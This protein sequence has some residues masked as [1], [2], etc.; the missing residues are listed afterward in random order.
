M[1]KP[2]TILALLLFTMI[3]HSQSL[4]WNQPVIICP[5]LSTNDNIPNFNESNCQTTSILNI[6]PQNQHI[7]IKTQFNVSPK[8]L[9]QS[10]PLGLYIVG[11]ASTV[12]YVNEQ[13]IGSNGTPAST[14]KEEIAGKIDTVFYLDKKIINNKDDNE[15]IIRMSAQKNLIHLSHPINGIFIDTYNNP[16][17][18]LLNHYWF[19]ILPFG[20]FVLAAIYLGVLSFRQKH[21]KTILFLSLMSLFA[22]CQLLI[23]IIRG[24]QSYLYPFHDIR[25]ILIVFFSY[26]F[27]ISLYSHIVYKFVKKKQLSL[28]LAVMLLNFIIIL[29]VEAYD[30]KAA[31][32]VN[33]PAFLALLICLYS[34]YQKQSYALLF[35]LAL[36][37]FIALFVISPS[38]FLDRYFYYVVAC[39]LVFLFIQQALDLSNQTK[40]H[41][42]EKARADQLQL[43]IDQNNEKTNPAQLKIKG[44]GQLTLIALDDIAYC[45]GAGDYVEIFKTDNNSI[46][47]NGTL[48]ELEMSLPVIF[49]KVHRSYIVNT[50]KIISLDRNTSG[51]GQLNLDNGQ[52]IPVS[53]RIMPKVRESLG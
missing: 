21:K 34:A 51:T 5:V 10:E 13:L 41:A 47:Y 50:T 46:L 6:N 39:L 23:E 28:I 3:A 8:F 38:V 40:I 20:A 26:A 52:Y 48:K 9:E 2:I 1:N 37:I 19:S 18:I 32:A 43:I 25:L 53:R 22:A 35:S 12:V 14:I 16:T 30:L 15:L 11:K 17:H 44:A 36:I 24:T 33:L 29:F 49:L 4:D 31:L 45:K 7:W 42:K 27:G